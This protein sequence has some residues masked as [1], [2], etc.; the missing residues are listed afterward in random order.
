MVSKSLENR[1]FGSLA[2][3]ITMVTL[4]VLNAPKTP[5]KTPYLECVGVHLRRQ[6]SAARQSR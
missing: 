1:A 4:G 5:E 6:R 2:P 3:G